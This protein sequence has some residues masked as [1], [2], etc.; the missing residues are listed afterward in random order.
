M[1]WL[2]KNHIVFLTGTP[3][4]GPGEL[5]RLLEPLGLEGKITTRYTIAEDEIKQLLYEKGISHLWGVKVL[6]ED[7][8]PPP[9]RRE[10]NRWRII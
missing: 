5:A 2:G 1:E 7:I 4:C 10:N 3:K 6:M 9:Y 8:L